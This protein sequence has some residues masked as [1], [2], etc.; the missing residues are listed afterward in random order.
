MIWVAIVLAV[1]LFYRFVTPEHKQKVWR[2]SKWVAAAALV[3]GVGIGCYAAYEDFQSGKRRRNEAAKERIAAERKARR[4]YFDGFK[5]TLR[6][7]KTSKV[8]SGIE[9]QMEFCNKSA[10]DLESIELYARGKF[11]GKSGSYYLSAIRTNDMTILKSDEIVPS[12]KCG[13]IHF[14][15]WGYVE[16]DQVDPILVYPEF[17]FDPDS[18]QAFEKFNTRAS[19][20]EQQDQ[21]DKDSEFSWYFSKLGT[22]P[23]IMKYS[24]TDQIKK[25]LTD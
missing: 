12:G 5:Y 18:Y 4:E 7:I 3:I 17:K 22:N 20:I 9:Y 2:A 1:F 10:T 21:A 11:R 23:L 19:L 24:S 8:K 6:H 25:L 16:V 14:S 15:D 13:I